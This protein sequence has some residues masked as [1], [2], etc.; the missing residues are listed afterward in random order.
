MG[1]NFQGCPT[2]S[3]SQFWESRFL[4]TQ[5]PLHISWTFN[6]HTHTHIYVYIIYII[7]V[8]IYI[9]ICY[10]TI[11]TISS[12]FQ[13]HQS[14]HRVTPQ[15]PFRWA[16]WGRQPRSPPR[17]YPGAQDFATRLF[18]KF[19]HCSWEKIGKSSIIFL[20]GS[21]SRDLITHVLLNQRKASKS[22]FSVKKSGQTI[23]NYFGWPW[24]ILGIL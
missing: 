2:N 12:Q 11:Q 19:A 14:C 16:H 22:S 5:R 18:S 21:V 6:K 4:E 15:P 17:S 9:Y 23:V 7:H 20:G 8:Y 3:H 10:T 24:E 1:F 13:I